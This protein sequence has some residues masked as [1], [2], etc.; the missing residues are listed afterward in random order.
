MNF[1]IPKPL[2]TSLISFL[3][4]SISSCSKDD[5]QTKIQLF[6]PE[7]KN[8]H[9]NSGFTDNGIPI[10]ADVWSVEYVKDVVSGEML[11]D[12]AGEPLTLK[13]FGSI[14]IQDG[15]L[16]LEKQDGDNLLT[17]SLKENFDANPRKFSIGILADGKRDEISFT[18]TR[19][20]AYAIVK[21]QIAEVPGSRKEYTS[22]E[23]IPSITLS[24]NTPTPI[25][26]ETS[27]IFKDVYYESEF[28]SDDYGAFD[29]LNSQD[30]LI[31]MDE[32]I[33][34]GAAYWAERVPYKK[35]RTFVPFVE[36]P[37][38]EELLVHPLTNINVRGEVLYLERE[39]IYT[40]TIKNLSSG[41][42]FDISGT[43]KQKLPISHTTH[44]Y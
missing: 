23:G 35:G 22:D 44:I 19:G 39:S 4:I 16:E 12:Q 11:L 8:L 31:F 2:T 10:D 6:N 28:I 14:E 40:F 3:L 21:K 1:K 41:N 43:W 24:N 26:M 37:S 32:V 42:T 34:E 38:K 27:V 15:W 33:R 20:E 5:L 18:Q 25:N 29:W 7:Y 36:S 9:L 30:T 17:I 13:A